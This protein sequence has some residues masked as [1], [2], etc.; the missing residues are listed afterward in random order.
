MTTN[1]E[2]TPPRKMLS[3][4]ASLLENDELMTLINRLLDAAN[5]TGDQG[6]RGLAI[7]LFAELDR[8]STLYSLRDGKIVKTG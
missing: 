1:A 7:P 4:P 5:G 6:E 3:I 2:N 8:R